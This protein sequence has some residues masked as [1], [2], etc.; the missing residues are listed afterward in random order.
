MEECAMARINECGYL[1]RRTSSECWRS[2]WQ[3]DYCF[4]LCVGVVR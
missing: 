2:C 4:N 3:K 1:E